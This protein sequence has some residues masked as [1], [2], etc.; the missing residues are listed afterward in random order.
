MSA[1]QIALVPMDTHVLIQ[2]AL[3]S[4]RLAAAKD[5]A[6]KR[7]LLGVRS[8]VIE[9]IVPFFEASSACLVFA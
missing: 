1:L 7:F 8:E 5:W 6:Y 9:K 3:L 4:E 2:V